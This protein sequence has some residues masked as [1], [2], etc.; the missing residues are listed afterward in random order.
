M[1]IYNEQ[2]GALVRAIQM[3][4][5]AGAAEIMIRHMDKARDDLIGAQSR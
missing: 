4:D 3:R 5:A 1:R 2:H